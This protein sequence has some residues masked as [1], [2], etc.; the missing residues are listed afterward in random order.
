MGGVGCEAA[1]LGDSVALLAGAATA[2]GLRALAV[3]TGFTL[4]AWPSGETP[5]R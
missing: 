5:P 2:T 1:G 3:F 4:P